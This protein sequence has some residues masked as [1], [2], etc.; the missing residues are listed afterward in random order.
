[1]TAHNTVLLPK[2]PRRGGGA[3]HGKTTAPKAHCV[4]TDRDRENEK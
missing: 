4:E 1:M 2:R 3:P